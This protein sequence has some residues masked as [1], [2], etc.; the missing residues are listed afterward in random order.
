R[1]RGQRLLDFRPNHILSGGQ[2]R[3][4]VRHLSPRPRGPTLV[5]TV[6]GGRQRTIDQLVCTA[7]A[8]VPLETEAPLMSQTVFSPVTLLRHRMSALPSPVKAPTHRTLQLRAV[9]AAMEAPLETA[10]PFMS[11]IAFSPVA[12]WRHRMS[13]LPSPLKSPTPAM[14][15]LGSDTV[16]NIAAL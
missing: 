13:D 1:L 2:G 5:A 3:A 12:R 14:V 6:A 8:G 16:A 4:V 9:T 10:A 11:Q 7:L 15:Q